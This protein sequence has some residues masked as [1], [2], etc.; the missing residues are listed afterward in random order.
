M[1]A[2]ERWDRA[3]TL[4]H[5]ALERAPVDRAAFLRKACQ[6]DRD[7]ETDVSALLAAHEDAGSFAEGSPIGRSPR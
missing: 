2:S 1:S 5:Q 7:V 3:K 4:F 6:G